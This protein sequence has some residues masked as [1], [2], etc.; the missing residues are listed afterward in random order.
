MSGGRRGRDEEGANI[1]TME[2]SVNSIKHD[3]NVNH[4]NDNVEE[5]YICRLAR[6][7]MKLSNH[8]QKLMTTVV[9]CLMKVSFLVS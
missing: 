3:D 9:L 2:D 6:I 7:W 5:L 1:E 4:N 8:E